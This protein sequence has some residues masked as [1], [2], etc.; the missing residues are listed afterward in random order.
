VGADRSYG[1]VEMDSTLSTPSRP[2]SSLGQNVS[3]KSH[4]SIP[5]KAQ[6][7]ISNNGVSNSTNGSK[8]SP[9][10]TIQEI[11]LVEQL[12]KLREIKKRKESEIR[13]VRKSFFEKVFIKF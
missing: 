12:Q 2:Q 8:G 1:I 7:L 9:S 11:S 3:T 13:E 5:L 4:S 6:N 10:P